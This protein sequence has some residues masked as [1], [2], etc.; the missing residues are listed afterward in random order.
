MPKSSLPFREVMLDC[1]PGQILLAL[2]ESSSLPE[3]ET[4]TETVIYN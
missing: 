4:K 2:S 1:L 3:T